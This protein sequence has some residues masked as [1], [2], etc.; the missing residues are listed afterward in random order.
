M[1]P[2]I[3]SAPRLTHP[4]ADC[5]CLCR[6]LWQ[7]TSDLFLGDAVEAPHFLFGEHDPPFQIVNPLEPD[8]QRALCGRLRLLQ[9]GAHYTYAAPVTSCTAPALP[10]FQVQKRSARNA[11]RPAWKRLTM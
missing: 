1:L 8:G 11:T 3:F 9:G 2:R 5:M 7:E 10:S 4:I 6:D